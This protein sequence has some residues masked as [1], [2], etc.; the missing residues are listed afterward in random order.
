MTILNID[1]AIDKGSFCIVKENNILVFEEADNRTQLA[2]WLH[3]AIDIAIKK[4]GLSPGDLDAVAVSNGPG[5]Y[6]GLRISLAT[7]K[8]L[9]YALGI[10]LICVN[11]LQVMAQAVAAEA[12]DL[13]SPMIDARRMEVFTALYAQDIMIKQEAF[14]LILDSGS[15]ADILKNREIL[16]TGNGSGKFRKIIDGNINARFIEKQ[17]DARDM[18]T[19]STQKYIEKSFSDVAYCEP[20]YV[21]DV[22]INKKV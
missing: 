15:F 7:A 9:C 5:S 16:F 10:P 13:I 18:R 20:Y 2:G 19:I 4:A 21:K 22:Y 3:K 6:T 14:A 11:T 1:T 12:A 8:G 17:V